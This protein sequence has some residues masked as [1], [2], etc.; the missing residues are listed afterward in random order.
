MLL[1]DALP[2]IRQAV[3]C[4]QFLKASKSHLYVCPFCGSGENGKN[5]T[6]ALKVYEKTNTWTC[7]ACKSLQRDKYSGDVIDLYR[8]ETGKDFMDAVEDLAQMAGI[9]IDRGHSSARDDF[10]PYEETQPAAPLDPDPIA[11][12]ADYTQYYRQ[13]MQALRESA[14]AQAYLQARGFSLDLAI[15]Y[16]I[17]FDPQ[18]DPASAPG[19]MGDAYRPHPC[20]R[21][22]IPTTP[23]HYVARSIDPD[24][25]ERYK[26]LNPNRDRGAGEPG[27]FG[28]K[29]AFSGDNE[30]I[31]VCEGWADALS[32]AAA[33]QPAIALNS[34]SNADKLI[35][36]LE[37]RPTQATM[38][39]C[40]DN[41]AAGKAATEALKEGLKRLNIPFLMANICGPYKDPNEFLCADQE[42]FAGAVARVTTAKPDN[43]SLYLNTFMADDLARRQKI[44]KKA[45]GFPNLDNVI[46]GG[47]RPGL[48]LLGAI[49]SLGKTTFCSQLADG[50]AR[51]GS[52][53]IYFSL[54]QSRLEMVS[55]SLSRQ[56]YQIDPDNAVTG[57]Q[58]MDGCKAP[59]IGEAMRQ[60]IE[61]VGDRVSIIEAGFNCDT[62]YITDYVR[63]YY[64]KTGKR[65]VVFIDY[66]QV[67]KPG[68]LPNGR[69]QDKRETVEECLTQLVLLKRELDLTI[70][71][72]VSLNR[73]N[74]L[75]PF[76]FESIKETGLAE[77]SADVVWGLQLQALEDPLFQDKEKIKDKRDKIRAEK[78]AIPRKVKLSSIKHRGQQAVYDCYFE[79]MPQ[80][81]I[82]IPK[83][84]PTW[85][86]QDNTKT[87]PGKGRKTAR[88]GSRN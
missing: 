75:Q 8:H 59:I 27:I 47:L 18:A 78:G 64:R 41:D 20:P 48:I 86:Q 34:A 44:G 3:D 52:D 28:A 53:V 56:T 76:D 22:I 60:Y 72:I 31:F 63:N 51:N 81:D 65:P 19:A 25:P 70:L 37:E 77:Y 33:G 38:V 80:Y 1:K 84:G 32:V 4:K 17:G 12:Q 49:S 82:F 10:T 40:L 35:K 21:I 42:G 13:C 88:P 16:G 11:P 46:G 50:L 71:A 55:K 83:D 66:L 29:K 43:V 74:Y 9:T 6:G 7:F 62:Q 54:E 87:Y 58:I 57:S 36:Q 79:Y 73:N 2:I 14:P 24:T 45:T 67:L 5:N 23:S 69:K 30:N 61:Q 68:E 15:S 26:K 85:Q 39:L